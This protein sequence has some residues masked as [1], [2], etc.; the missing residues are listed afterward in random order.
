M[1]RTSISPT[2]DGHR[3]RTFGIVFLSLFAGVMPLAAG[4]SNSCKS[5]KTVEEFL[6]LWNNSVA[7]R[8][9]RSRACTLQLMTSDARITGA[10]TENDKPKLIVENPQEFVRWYQEHPNEQF[11]ER[12]LHSTVDVYENVAR[13]TRT[14]EVRDSE[15]SPVKS[16][17]IEDF[18]LIFR[19]GRWK[20]F[21]MLWQDASAKHPLP[22]RYLP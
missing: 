9:D 2:I 3:L 16:T 5:A 6:M 12:T 15:H 17:G 11:W 7:G 18:Q 21:A 22:T 14:Y 8:G 1:E 10:I 20:A 4:Q 19:D 13:V